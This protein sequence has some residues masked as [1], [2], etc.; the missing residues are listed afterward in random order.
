MNTNI[1]IGVLV[2]FGLLLICSFAALSEYQMDQ[3]SSQGVKDVKLKDGGTVR[4]V[5]NRDYAKYPSCLWEGM[6]ACTPT[7]TP[8]TP[9]NT[10]SDWAARTATA[11]ANNNMISVA[12]ARAGATQTAENSRLFPSPTPT[13]K[14]TDTPVP[15]LLPGAKTAIAA[16]TLSAAGAN[17]AKPS[18]TAN[19]TTDLVVG[20]KVAT[21][22][23]IALDKALATPEPDS[24]EGK[25]Q[26]ASN[27]WKV[28]QNPLIALVIGVIVLYLIFGKGG[29]NAIGTLS[30]A[31]TKLFTHRIG[32][33]II[34]AIIIALIV[35]WLQG[36][37]SP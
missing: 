9:T 7:P 15:T 18:P 23:I 11:I 24:P 5:T 28:I 20:Q 16:Q 12:Q 8:I 19:A 36:Q 4:L 13:L 6:P 1:I 25:I 37:L 21:A 22:T 14:P 29:I 31:I 2:I 33:Y 17:V 32:K 26:G 35:L 27:S 10:P 34:G 30:E 3:L